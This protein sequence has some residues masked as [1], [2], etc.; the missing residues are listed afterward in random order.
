M[1]RRTVREWDEIDYDPDPENPR[2]LPRREADLIAAAAKAS[3]LAGPSGESVIDHGRH[4]LRAK[5]VVGVVAADGCALEI[6]P[7]IDFPGESGEQAEGGIRRRLVQML[8]VAHDMD[9]GAGQVTAMDWQRETLLEI[10]IKLFSEQLADAVR[11]GMPRSYVAQEEDLA[12][13]R[14]RLDLA[15][16]FTV[17]AANPARL[18]CRF[19]ELSPDIELNRAMKAAVKRLSWVSQS[20][21]NL[22]RLRELAFAYADIAAVSASALAWNKIILDRTNARWRQL[23]N[24]AKLLLDE[25]FQTTSTGGGAGFSLLFDMSELFEKYVA[26][27]VV[28][29]LAGGKL[30]AV[31]QGGRKYCLEDDGG[32]GY[33]QTKP[34][35][36]VKGNGSKVV[37][38][39]DTKWKRVESPNDA[40][41]KQGVSQSDVYQIMAYGQLYDCPRLTLLYPHHS[42]L[43]GEGGIQVDYRVNIEATDRR[44]EIATVNVAEANQGVAEQLRCLLASARNR[45][46]EAG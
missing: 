32:R 1:I 31:P 36:L 37:Q 11:Q 14:G 9:I 35:I 23:L 24:L 25:R 44:L 22:R 17:L 2:T 42:G 41:P 30:R 7:K 43:S 38:I 16:Q 10:L 18:A 8:A 45:P 39:I 27:M 6:L 20:E 3:P 19:D 4:S 26:C 13:L 28:N 29:S 40:D 21:D 12:V 33:F 46:A 15:R 5:G 34:D